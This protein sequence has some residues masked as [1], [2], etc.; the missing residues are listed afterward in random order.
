MTCPIHV[1]EAVP[2]CV[3]RDRTA[4]C[5]E[6]VRAYYAG[7]TMARA[8]YRRHE[9]NRQRTAAQAPVTYARGPRKGWRKWRGPE[10]PT[11]QPQIARGP[12]ARA[13]PTPAPVRDEMGRWRS[14]A[15][16]SGPGEP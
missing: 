7:R 11:Y 16:L 10:A 5:V 2:C 14:A 9:A 12:S 1:G 8:Q 4:E 15:P 3:C 6:T 13:H